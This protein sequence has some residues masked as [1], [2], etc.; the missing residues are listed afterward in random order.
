MFSIDFLEAIRSAE[1]EAVLPELR[2]DMRLLEFGAGTG[3][4]ARSLRDIGYD[5]TAIDLASS[6]YADNRVY[7]IID[8]DGRHIPL[9]DKSIDL[10]FSSNVLEH[11]EDFPQIAREF[12]RITQSGGYG[13]HLMPSAGW[14]AWTLL[15]GLP[16]ALV[17]SAS[18][19]RHAV[20]PRRGESRSQSIMRDAK[21]A[22]TSVL[23]LGHGTAIEAFSELY[24]FSAHA[25]CR[26]FA[27][28]GFKVVSVKPIG[29]FHT[30][31]QLFGRTLSIARRRQLASTLGSAANVFV[32][33]PV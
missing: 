19:A 18:L 31:H 2:R 14:R 29:L 24:T 21:I 22:V 12:H 30:G 15:A 10:I 33:T 20:Q 11:V 4:Q 32:V 26:R 23:P 16:N 27:R 17:A 6:G 25:W 9:E 13:V 8:Y 3:I 1:L 28:H 7:P 5:V